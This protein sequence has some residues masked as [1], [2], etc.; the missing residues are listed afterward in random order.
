MKINKK[1]QVTIPAALRAK[2][3]IVPGCDVKIVEHGESLLIFRVGR[4]ERWARKMVG[5]G[6]VNMSTDEILEMTR[7][8]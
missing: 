5:Q 4:G 6:T 7:G 3:G 1:G 2:F 8:R